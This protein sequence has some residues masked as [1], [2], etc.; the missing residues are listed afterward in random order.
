M[1]TQ[2]YYELADGSMN[3]PAEWDSILADLSDGMLTD[4]TRVS[5]GGDDPWVALRVA[6]LRHLGKTMPAAPAKAAMPSAPASQPVVPVSKVANDETTLESA[7]RVVGILHLLA[8]VGAVIFTASDVGL[9]VFGI[10][11]ALALWVTGMFFFAIGKGLA[12]LREILAEM[13][14][15]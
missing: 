5:R 9:L 12:Y 15:R 7:F 1:S 11:I 2:Y 10:A 3:G 14:K 8:G 4:E 13:K 6:K